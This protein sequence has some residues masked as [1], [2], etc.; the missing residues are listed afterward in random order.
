[1]GGGSLVVVAG[2]AGVRDLAEDDDP[3]WAAV[4][5]EGTAGADVVVDGEDEGISR[6]VTRLGNTKAFRD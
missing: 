4:N 2:G 3:G 6:V 5:A 1:M